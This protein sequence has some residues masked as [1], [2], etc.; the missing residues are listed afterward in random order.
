MPRDRNL[1]EQNKKKTAYHLVKDLT[2]EKQA[3]P[4]LSR[5]GLG[6]VLLL[7]NKRFPADGQNI[8]LN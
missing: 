1:P 8:A 7:K 4:Q 2:S 6:T 5:T 3:D